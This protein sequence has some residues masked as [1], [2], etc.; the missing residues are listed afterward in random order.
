MRQLQ[1]PSFLFL[2]Y[3]ATYYPLENL[4]IKLS[5]MQKSILFRFPE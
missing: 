2:L 3:V 4:L 5:S 1:Q